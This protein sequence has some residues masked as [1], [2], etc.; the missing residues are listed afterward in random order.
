MAVQ[1]LTNVSNRYRQSHIPPI[2]LLY[3]ASIVVMFMQVKLNVIQVPSMVNA[4]HKVI[5][6]NHSL[7]VPSTWTAGGRMQYLASVIHREAKAASWAAGLLPNML[8]T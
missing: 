5:V 3:N 8:V 7:I 6:T 1:L 4:A 2:S